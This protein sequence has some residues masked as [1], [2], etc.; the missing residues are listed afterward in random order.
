MDRS[1]PLLVV[2]GSWLAWAAVAP[3]RP[4]LPALPAN[5]SLARL[6]NGLDVLLLHLPDAPMT[7]LNVQV[8]AGSARESFRTSGM[9]H[10]LEHLLFNGTE[11]WDQAAL[12]ER[13]D[14][15]GAYNNANTGRHYT[16]FMLLLPTADLAGGMELQSQML[17][18]S[19]LPPEKF[20]KERGIVLEELAQ[21]G[22]D[23]AQA[24]ETLWEDF[25]YA[26]SSFALPVLGTPATIRHMERDQVLDYYRT[27]YVPNNMLLSV[28]GG[29]D[30]STVL[31]EVERWY[32]GA[33]P[34]DSPAWR[35]TPIQWR[36]GE[37]RSRRAAVPGRRLRLAWPAPDQTE[38]GHLAAGLLAWAAGDPRDGVLP[39]LLF[40]EG[41]PPMSGLRL[42]HLDE[43]GGGRFELE[44][45]L[46]PG[47]EA[48]EAV[49]GL[50]RAMAR[51]Q[52]HAFPERLIAQRVLEERSSLA[53]L[54]EKPHYFGLMEAAAFAQQG[55]EPV[56]TRGARLAALGPGDLRACAA[57]WLAATPPMALLLEPDSTP[58]TSRAPR[59]ADRVREPGGAGRPAL[60]VEGGRPSEVF[61]LQILVRGRAVWEGD[62]AAGGLTLIHQL[63]QEGAAGQGAAQL[64][65]RLRRVG[66]KLTVADNP[67][68]PYDDHYTSS[69]HSFLRLE[70]LGEHWQA[71]CSL[72][73]DLLLRPDLPGT[74]LAR[75][76]ERQL[77]LLGR[78]DGSA[79]A[80]SRQL[81]DSLTL[82]GL[83]AALPPEGRPGSMARLEWDDL[84]HLHAVAFRPENLIVAAL[85]PAPAAEMADCLRGLLA[86]FPVSPPT[87]DL[88]RLARRSP[89]MREHTMDR[90]LWPPRL[91]APVTSEDLEL[92]ETLG[93]EMGA[94]RLGSRL[95][96][97]PADGPALRL[98]LA[99]LSDRM[100][101]DLR[102]ERGLA[103]SIGC[104]A[105]INGE[106]ATL[107]AYMGTRPENMAEALAG[108][109][110][111][112]A[113]DHPPVGQ[114]E[115][116]KVR[117]GLLGRELMRSL[118]SINQAWRLAMA[119]LGG[120]PEEAMGE[121]ESLRAVRPEDLA[122]VSRSY[123]APA[124]WIT[125]VVQ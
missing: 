60:I 87:E 73:V 82:G 21:A 45:D 79:R 68:I 94:L 109:R 90:P 6:D 28:V 23:P 91:L 61:A 17:F 2:V 27:W 123:L 88:A 84:R 49:E 89:W 107:E 74:A 14:R 58:A 55:F 40:A 15:L 100:A 20:G 41:L 11:Q 65:E 53:Q 59:E 83:P 19:I 54:M 35:V 105:A 3:A 9:T 113:A 4:P 56:L 31:A 67:A 37:I 108:L 111:H 7:G 66:G 32:G 26:G 110:R 39:A 97:D 77:E 102:E 44:A 99:V 71:A 36:P 70:A 43:A 57:R 125:I 104:G 114:D 50:A 96:I 115:L 78:R 42:S 63:M 34:G 62:S 16:N 112:L 1:L 121:E 101:F 93:G 81:L 117:G 52:D 122:R 51:L 10:M 124:R 30:P 72:A 46:P 106:R 13:Q 76:K 86:P 38:A 5:A 75:L 118:A 18:H 12:Y 47:L 119:E 92:S 24:L 64:A 103:Y 22:D 80:R 120:R 29:F 25:L 116:D 85:G 95:A 69:S 98:L 8:K 33:V 48:G